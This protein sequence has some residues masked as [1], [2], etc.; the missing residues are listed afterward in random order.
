MAEHFGADDSIIITMYFSTK[1]RG[2][3]DNQIAPEKTIMCDMHVF[4][5]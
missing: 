2:V 3:S 4:H 5:Q 1:F